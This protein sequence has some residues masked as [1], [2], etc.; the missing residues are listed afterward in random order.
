MSLSAICPNFKL[1]TMWNDLKITGFKTGKTVR[2]A[3]LR[4]RKSRR[5]RAVL[6]GLPDR[7]LKDLGIPRSSI[8]YRALE[9]ANLELPK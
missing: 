2:A 5:T 3:S 4:R 7:T 1:L 8:P 9:S 6:G